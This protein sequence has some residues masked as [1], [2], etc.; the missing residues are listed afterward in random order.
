MENVVLKF[1]GQD[2]TLTS[3][4]LTVGR[5]RGVDVVLEGANISRR[6]ARFFIKDSRVWVED[7]GSRNG[8]QVNGLRIQGP[9]QIRAGDVVQMGTVTV[10]LDAEEAD[11]GEFTIGEETLPNLTNEAL[12]RE[13]PES[14]LKAVLA[15]AES[16]S[17]TLDKDSLC[18]RLADQL[19]SLFTRAEQAAVVVIGNGAQTVF[20]SQIESGLP[21]I[22]VS[23]SLIKKVINE[24]IGVLA[25]CPSPGFAEDSNQTLRLLGLQSVACAPILGGTKT[26]FGV[27][28]I[29]SSQGAGQFSTEDLRLLT[30]IALQVGLLMDNTRLHE[31]FLLQE[32]IKRELESARAIQMGFLAKGAL[33]SIAGRYGLHAELL[34]ASEVSGD[35]YD[36]FEK[37]DGRIGFCVADVAGKGMP[38]ALFMARA[39]AIGR[40]IALSAGTVADWLKAWN[41]SLAMDN[42]GMIFITALCGFLDPATGS[43]ELGSAGHPSPFLRRTGGCVEPVKLRPARLLGIDV[44]LGEMTT[45]SLHLASGDNLLLYTDGLT[46]AP[47]VRPSRVGLGDLGLLEMVKSLPADGSLGVWF[48]MVKDQIDAF[49]GPMSNHDDRTLLIIRGL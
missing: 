23:R 1:P 24:R 21:R 14:K 37:P 13:N 42:P 12:F 11:F 41:R 6:H 10:C 47:S 35:F 48:E 16:L 33:P 44:D 34:P 46:E 4:G 32:R 29:A 2:R 30:I 31:E 26:V 45:S 38:A 15:I 39:Q 43:L 40:T 17:R 8:T 18:A 20:G 7:I 3:A 22:G 5:Q 25:G 36:Y 9:V 28:Q 27:I 49:A 19:V